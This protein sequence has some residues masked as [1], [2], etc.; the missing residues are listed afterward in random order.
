MKLFFHF[1]LPYFFLVGKNSIS[2]KLQLKHTQYNKNGT[3]NL[4]LYIIHII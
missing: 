3:Y 1:M 2:Y 4:K